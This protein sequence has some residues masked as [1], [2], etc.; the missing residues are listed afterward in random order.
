MYSSDEHEDDE[1]QAMKRAQRPAQ[2]A[3]ELRYKT[4]RSR[5][6]TRHIYTTRERLRESA[7]LPVRLAP[8][9]IEIETEQVKLKDVF[10]WNLNGLLIRCNLG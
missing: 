4:D 8:V 2:V 6:P 3:T 5:Q 1:I 9:K 10:T 7:E